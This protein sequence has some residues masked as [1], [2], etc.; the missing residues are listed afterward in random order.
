MIK[1]QRQNNCLEETP[2]HT[3]E[4]YYQKSHKNT[5]THTH[6]S[7]AHKFWCGACHIRLHMWQ[8]LFDRL[9]PQ[10]QNMAHKYSI[11]KFFFPFKH[12]TIQ[13]SM[14]NF[15]QFSN[16]LPQKTFFS[17]RQIFYSKKKTL[18]CITYD[19]LLRKSDIWKFVNKNI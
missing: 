1:F 17:N 8:K 6:M 12:D 5:H 11:L 9:P 7:K 13:I 4:F 16:N 2:Q 18:L 10:V 19:F 3:K 15:K 14:N